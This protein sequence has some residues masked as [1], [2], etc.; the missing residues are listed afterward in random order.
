MPYPT[1]GGGFCGNKICEQGENS[2]NC[3][4][5]CGGGPTRPG[6]QGEQWGPDGMGPGGPSEE[7]MQRMDEQRFQQMKKGL[8]QFTRGVDQMKKMVTRMEKKLKQMGVAV[9]PELKAALDKAPEIVSRIKNA[10]TPDELEDIIA[11][12]EDI[13]MVMQEWGPRFGDLMRLGGMLKQGD[14][15]LKKVRSTVKRVSGY[16]KGNPTIQELIDELRVMANSLAETLKNAKRMALA[17][18]TPSLPVLPVPKFRRGD[19]NADGAIDVT[20]T[21]FF[22]NILSADA[23][24]PCQD[25]I[26]VNDDGTIDVSDSVY[27]TEWQTQG[28][29]EP[30]GPGPN[31]IGPDPTSDSLGCDQYPKGTTFTATTPLVVLSD[32]GS[33]LDMLDDDFFGRMEE[34]WNQVNL[35]EMMKNMKKGVSEAE[36]GVKQA[37][38]T[39]TQLKKKKVDQDVIEELQDILDETKERLKEFKDL[40]K[41]KG[42]DPEDIR[43]VGEELWDL[44]IRFENAL[45]EVGYGVYQPNVKGGENVNFVMP[46]GFMGGGPSM[47]PGGPGEMGPGGPGGFGPSEPMGPGGFGGF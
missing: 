8:S 21:L 35:I 10:K 27:F 28:G 22:S 47:G 20:D 31:T 1:Q 34:F 40:M 6:G 42:V 9:P 23:E 25:A 36:R 43:A 14:R 37:E 12:V 33:A 5:D 17:S 45:A 29:P 32:P 41:Q 16:G 13:G 39:I 4:D 3:H 18:D 38:R 2:S 19:F 44:K 24:R 11:D 15:E 30:K 26:D 46:E 7:E